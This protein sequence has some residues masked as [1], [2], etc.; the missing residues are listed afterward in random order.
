VTFQLTGVVTAHT[1]KFLQTLK[2]TVL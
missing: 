1:Q 2:N